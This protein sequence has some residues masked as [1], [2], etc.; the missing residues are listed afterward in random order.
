MNLRLIR[1]SQYISQFSFD[2]KWKVKKYNIIFDALLQLLRKNY[3]QKNFTNDEILNEISTYYVTL[4][5]IISLFKNNWRRFTKLIKNDLKFTKC[6]L[7]NAK[8]NNDN[9]RKSQNYLVNSKQILTKRNFAII[10]LTKVSTLTT[11]TQ[12]VISMLNIIDTTSKKSIKSKTTKRKSTI[13]ILTTSTT[14]KNSKKTIILKES[15][16]LKKSIKLKK[17]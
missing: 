4:I 11:K 8:K 2:I 12:I 3:S 17:N 10:I 16:I 5:E 15:T 13:I 6:F 7:V 9:R 1:V 14:L